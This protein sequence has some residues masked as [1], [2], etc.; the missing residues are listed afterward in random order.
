MGTSEPGAQV[1]EE[2]GGKEKRAE[3]GR[4]RGEGRRGRGWEEK[5]VN[6]VGQRSRQ[7]PFLDL[8]TEPWP[9]GRWSQG[10]TRVQSLGC[11]C[12]PPRTRCCPNV[13][14]TGSCVYEGR[15]AR[16]AEVGRA[17]EEGSGLHLEMSAWRRR[18]NCSEYVGRDNSRNP[19]KGAAGPG[20]S[21]CRP[22]SFLRAG[23]GLSALAPCPQHPAHNRGS[24]VH[25]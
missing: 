2:R 6:W 18:V 3:K 19:N 7:R 20:E 25:C 22:G 13:S 10:Q 24:K 5:G 4:K 9:R 8:G 12:P 23:P 15:A 1:T 17:Q 21:L 14:S 11:A 16:A